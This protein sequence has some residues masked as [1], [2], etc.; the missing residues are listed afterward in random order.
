MQGLIEA[1]LPAQL[2]K[3]MFLGKGGGGRESTTYA[4]F[5]DP[6]HLP[7]AGNPQPNPMN[8]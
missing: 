5:L 6:T 2:D 4:D 1:A 8:R 7:H 3:A